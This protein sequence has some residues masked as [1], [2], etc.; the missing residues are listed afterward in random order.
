MSHEP[1]SSTLKFNASIEIPMPY[2]GLC[3]REAL[4]DDSPAFA[5]SVDSEEN[6]SKESTSSN[7]NLADIASNFVKNQFVK[8]HEVELQGKDSVLPNISKV[9]PELKLYEFPRTDKT[10]STNADSSGE[11]KKH[12]KT[13]S[14]RISL[15]PIVKGTQVSGEFEN[16]LTEEKMKDLYDFVNTKSRLIKNKNKN[17]FKNNF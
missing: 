5:F 13:N 17:L 1:F 4:L 12:S 7:H 10:V 2:T 16:P 6:E 3:K 9:S 8:T 11:S 14:F 15:S